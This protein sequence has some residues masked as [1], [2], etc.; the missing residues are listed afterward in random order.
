MQPEWLKQRFTAQATAASKAQSEPEQP[1]ALNRRHFLHSGMLTGVTAGLAAGGLAAQHRAAHAQP[2]SSANPLGK[3]WWPSPWGPTDERGAAN[4][5]TPAKVLE[6]VRL[7]KTGKVYQLGRVYEQGM[8][9]FGS[10][11]H[12]L[13]IPG[14]PTG[15]PFGDA[16]LLYNDEMFSGE[17]GQVGTQFDGLGHI[18]TLIGADVVYYNGLKQADVGG[19]F[20]LKKLGVHNVGVFFT[21]GILLDVLAYKGADRLPI[22]YVITPED[23]Q[24]TLRRQGIGEPG[25]GDV[26]LFHTGHGKLWMTDN[27]EYN[28]GEPGPS[29]SV[30]KW[31]IDKRICLVGGDNWADGGLARGGQGAPVR[32]PSVVDHHER[33][34]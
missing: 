32:V 25:E 8:P 23:V 33:H 21:R 9:L 22:G 14:G 30:A 29:V 5:V 34:L 17:I 11:H 7:I 27:A 2:A 31:L 28:K 18:G 24:G 4:R 10:R 13:S 1:S 19:S 3:E 20:G 15:G 16:K 6:A 12:S 26:V